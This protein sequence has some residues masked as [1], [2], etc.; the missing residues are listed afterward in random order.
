MAEN[1]LLKINS[2]CLF[3]GGVEYCVFGKLAGR[4]FL[5]K[6]IFFSVSFFIKFTLACG[7]TVLNFGFGTTFGGGIGTIS[8]LIFF[9]VSIK[10]LLS[11]IFLL[12][13]F[14]GTADRFG[15]IFGF[16]FF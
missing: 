4:L 10:L 11:P 1:G 16:S 3:V 7:V 5:F 2:F 14:D 15:E 6:S 12:T 9:E 13:F 8:A